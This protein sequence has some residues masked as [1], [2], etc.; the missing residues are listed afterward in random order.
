M[1][2]TAWRLLGIALWVA[3]GF[4]VET[5]APVIGVVIA[6][7]GMLLTFAPPKGDTR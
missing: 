1:N 3:G 2:T 4:L 5:E 7:V 6:L